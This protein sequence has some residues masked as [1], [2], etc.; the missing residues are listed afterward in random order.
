MGLN[1][2]PEFKPS[3]LTATSYIVRVIVNLGPPELCL[4]L[5][6][7]QLF[8]RR[9]K[10]ELKDGVIVKDKVICVLPRSLLYPFA[11]YTSD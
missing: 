4:S 5:D 9:G 11:Y 7:K 2:G 3:F 1:H 10:A 8:D 6:R